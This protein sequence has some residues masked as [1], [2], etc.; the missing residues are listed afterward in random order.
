M[1]IYTRFVGIRI[2]VQAKW[3]TSLSSSIKAY[4]VVDNKTNFWHFIHKLENKF[5]YSQMTLNYARIGNSLVVYFLFMMII[6]LI[7]LQVHHC[8]QQQERRR[9]RLPSGHTNLSVPYEHH[10]RQ[11]KVKEA[12]QAT[13]SS[14]I[15]RNYILRNTFRHEWQKI[16]DGWCIHFKPVFGRDWNFVNFEPKLW[17]EFAIYRNC[18]IQFRPL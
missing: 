11:D 7:P 17:F 3:N 5:Q 1:R 12:P 16:S 10:G 14:T 9:G 4:H 18:Q 2:I 13:I 8:H 15:G 6:F